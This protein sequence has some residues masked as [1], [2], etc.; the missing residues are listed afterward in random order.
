M[1]TGLRWGL[2]LWARVFLVSVGGVHALRH[3]N[4]SQQVRRAQ[5]AGVPAGRTKTKGN[6]K[7]TLDRTLNRMKHETPGKRLKR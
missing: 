7:N 5:S 6:N 3:D 1:G 2:Y 4:E